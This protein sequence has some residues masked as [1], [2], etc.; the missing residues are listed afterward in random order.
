VSPDSVAKCIRGKGLNPSLKPLAHPG[1][2]GPTAYLNVDVGK[3]NGISV[4]F[5]DEHS[6]AA[7]Y[8]RDQNG[9]ASAGLNANATQLAGPKTAVTV[10]QPGGVQRELKVVTGCL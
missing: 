7:K 8:V 6:D 4:A 2:S 10:D 5:F 1:P 9:A 3:N